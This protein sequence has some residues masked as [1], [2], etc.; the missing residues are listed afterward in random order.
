MEEALMK[1]IVTVPAAAAVIVMA[2]MFLK[3]QRNQHETHDKLTKE[4]TERSAKCHD[5]CTTAVKENRVAVTENTVVL[6]KLATLI[7]TK[8][9]GG[10]P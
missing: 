8:I 7:E 3:A 2:W 1:L 10:P 6:T 9:D 4:I 5:E